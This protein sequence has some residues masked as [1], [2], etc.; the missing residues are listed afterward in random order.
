MSDVAIKVENLGKCYRLRH[1]AGRPRYRTLRDDMM[2]GPRRLWRALRAQQRT[3]EAFWALK[4]VSFEVKRG[5]VLGIIGR[6]GAGKSTLLKI[7]SRIVEPTTGA[8]DIY[9]RVGSLLEV[10]TGFHPELTGRE[11][12]FL[13]GAMLGMRRHEVRRR[14]DEIV[15]FAEVEKFL[16]TPCKHYSS[17]MYTRLGFAV[18]AHLDTDILVVDEV[19]AVGDRTFREKCLGKMSEVAQGGRTVLL[20]SHDL[21][22][23]NQLAS[24]CLWVDSGKISQLGSAA[25]VVGAYIHAFSQSDTT[26]GGGQVCF[27]QGMRSIWYSR[28]SLSSASGPGMVR[29]GE[30]MRLAIDINA[31]ND[32]VGRP[33]R[34]AITIRTEDGAPVALVA[35]IDSG[36]DLAEGIGTCRRI[37]IEFDDVRFYPGRYFIGL[38]IGSSDS[39]ETFDKRSDCLILQVIDGGKL[40]QR[41]LLRSQGVLFMQPTWELESILDAP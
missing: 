38:W 11:N 40:T 10:G 8:V 30:A 37:C 14:L 13:S 20:V 2:D 36:F 6:N 7:I 33:V 41:R 4:D 23:V 29:M 16:D 12:I 1:E 18:A 15:A 35:D 32:F 19:L 9:G 28:A 25:S 24:R 3:Q 5:E 34:L 21:A 22:A 17:G 39:L 31:R 26:G 27:E